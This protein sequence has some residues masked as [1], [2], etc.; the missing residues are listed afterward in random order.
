MST[1]SSGTRALP[2]P[3]PAIAWTVPLSSMRNTKFGSAPGARML[4]LDPLRAAARAEADQP[5]L[6]DELDGRQRGDAGQRRGGGGDQHERVVEQLDASNG[7]SGRGR[8]PNV[9]S[10]CPGPTRSMRP[11]SLAASAGWTSTPGQASAKRPM[12]AGSIRVPTLWYT[13]DAQRAGLARRVGEQVGAGRLEPVRDRLDVASSSRPASVS[14]TVRRP[15][16]RSNSRTPSARLE[17]HHV[18]ADRR[19]RVVERVGGP[20]ERA[21]VGDGAEAQQL[22]QA[23]VRERVREDRAA[24]SGRSRAPTK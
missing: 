2:S 9:M 4:V 21:L 19:L 11:S 18:L 1:A 12:I 14:S 16:P 13:P 17:R 20:V 15:R 7:P 23:E 6:A 3:A 22:A 5:L 8:T 24:G 10:S